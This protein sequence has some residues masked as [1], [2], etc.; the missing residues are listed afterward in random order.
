MIFRAKNQA[1]FGLV[2]MI[3]FEQKID[4]VNDFWRGVE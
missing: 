3:S 4:F 1:K 2:E